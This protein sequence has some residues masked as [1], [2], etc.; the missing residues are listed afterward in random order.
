[1]RRLVRTAI[2]AFSG[3]LLLL[4]TPAFAQSSPAAPEKLALG[5]WLFSPTMEARFRAE[6]RADAPDLGG[7]DFFGKNTPRVRNAWVVMDRSRLGLGAERGAIRAQITLQDA[8]ALGGSLSDAV[9]GTPTDRFA[10]FA[11]YEAYA[12]AHGSGARPHY[13]RLG[14]QAVVW[15]EGRLIG[16]AEFS[17][18]GRALDAARAHLTL[19]N[20][21]LEALGA[22][23]E[24]PG[25]LGSSFGDRDGPSSTGTQ[26]YGVTAKYS[27]DPLLKAELFGIA[28]IARSN[29]GDLD[30][31]RFAL[32]RL[33]SQKYTG[34]A[35]LS[36]EG[37]GWSWGAEG[38]LQGGS[39]SSLGSAT[40]GTDIAAWAAYGHLEKVVDQLLLAPTFRLEGSYASGDDGHGKYKQFDP[41]LPDPQRFHGPMDL[42]GWSNM[43]DLGA[44]VRMTP[45]NDT[46]VTLG[47]R[48]ARLVQAQ[49]EWIGGYMTAVGS[50][51][52]PPLTSSPRTTTNLTNE[53][54][55]G[56]EIDVSIAWRP[57]VPVEIRGGWSGLLL[58]TGAKAI[59][60]AHGRG[61]HETDGVYPSSLAQYAYL[62]ATVTIP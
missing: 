1:M 8:R 3:A 57:F 7:T 51:I 9:V 19:G 31:S 39:A 62:Q 50:A 2:P 28:R 58:G 42:F 11:P 18:S 16:N 53:K 48:Y 15:G 17:P 60:A 59:M 54:D 27:F 46:T 32:S 56:H 34:S 30:G 49:G 52:R 29:G 44:S 41:L 6:Y 38:A 61:S 40:P 37:G 36:G 14:R 43:I 12:E 45:A 25:P 4:A 35:R 21:D 47:Y 5:D 26:L 22:L 24:M 33:S 23:L 55:L 10:K 13:L 20:L